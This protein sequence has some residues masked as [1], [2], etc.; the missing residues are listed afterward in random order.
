LTPRR[1]GV[2]LLSG[3]LVARFHV[4]PIFP[5]FPISTYPQDVLRFGASSLS[6]ALHDGRRTWR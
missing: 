2:I 1:E 6:S 3:D 5:I 4:V